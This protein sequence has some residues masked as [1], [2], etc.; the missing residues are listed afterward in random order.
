VSVQHVPTGGI[1]PRYLESFASKTLL[2]GDLPDYDAQAWYRDKMVVVP[3][4]AADEDIVELVDHWVRADDEREALCEH[5]YAETLRTETSALRAAELAE[6][7]ARH[8]GA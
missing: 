4:D 1:T 3:E 6:I 2:I 5:A 8:I 7:V